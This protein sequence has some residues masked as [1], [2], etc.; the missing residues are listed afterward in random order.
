MQKLH[1]WRARVKMAMSDCEL[2][3]LEGG[4]QRYLAFFCFSVKDGQFVEKNK[5]RN[6][7]ANMQAVFRGAQVCVEYSQHVVPFA[8]SPPP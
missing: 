1:R 8:D 2:L 3:P 5:K 4:N 6:E 7:E